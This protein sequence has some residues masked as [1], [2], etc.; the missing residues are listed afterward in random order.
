M[1]TMTF[2]LIERGYGNYMLWLGAG[3]CNRA[4]RPIWGSMERV[5][6][7]GSQSVRRTV[8]LIGK[9]V[10]VAVWDKVCCPLLESVDVSIL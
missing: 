2:F 9:G 5:W 8:R 4:G 3:Q 10:W 7:Y 6:V 1:W